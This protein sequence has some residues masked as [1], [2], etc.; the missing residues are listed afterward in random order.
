MFKRSNRGVLGVV[1]IL[2]FAGCRSADVEAPG[3]P[4]DS[5]A[6][7]SLA[8][9]RLDVARTRF[10]TTVA[11]RSE[12]RARIVRRP[13]PV[14]K[15]G[16]VSG[17]EKSGGHLRPILAERER[18]QPRAARVALPNMA[19]D[20][21]LLEDTGSDVRASVTLRGA[22][23]TPASTADGHA[24]YVGGYRG[25]DIIH[26]VTAEGTEDF[27]HF[28]TKP[29]KESLEYDLDV[30]RVAGLRLIGDGLELLD[31]SGTP[32]IHVSPPWVADANG[33]HMARLS[34]EGCAFDSNPAPPWGRA[35]TPP[36]ADHC[37]VRVSWSDVAYPAL[38]DPSWTTTATMTVYRVGTS[39]TKL[40][41]GRVLFAADGS[42]T[43]TSE[44]YDPAT[45]TFALTGNMSIP[46]LLHM[47]NLLPSGKV[48]VASGGYTANAFWYDFT[49][50]TQIFDPA[51]GTWTTGPA[52]PF[53]G[54]PTYSASLANGDVLYV[55]GGNGAGA[56]YRAATG[57]FV[58]TGS[59]AQRRTEP[60]L[61]TLA[62]GKVLVT[63]GWSNDL[64]SGPIVGAAEIFDP[65]ANGG[66]GAFSAT[67]A[68]V[69]GRASHTATLLPSGK[70][71]IAG[72]DGAYRVVEIF[73]PAAAGG[74]GA[75]SLAPSM[76]WDHSSHQA[77]LLPSGR[78][79]I[80][81]YDGFIGAFRPGHN[82]AEELDPVLGSVVQTGSQFFG[83]DWTHTAT[84]LN[85][86][87]VLVGPYDGIHMSVYDPNGTGAPPPCSTPSPVT[88]TATNVAGGIKLDWTAA[89]TPGG[90]I[91]YYWK[92]NATW[93]IRQKIYSATTTTFTDPLPAGTTRKFRIKPYND[94][95]ANAFYDPSVDPLGTHSNEVTGTAL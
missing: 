46:R 91:I 50:D 18:S 6:E 64:A 90:Y 22:S 86:G 3:Q 68:M 51:L 45:N 56:I 92:N 82:V 57:T 52:L 11:E 14:L 33:K 79:L 30:S 93:S 94:C 16:A 13:V 17:F 15:A 37:T 81:G 4:D 75:F 58:T 80:T 73:D 69:A 88:L 40:Q 71:L 10:Q 61:T 70:V 77:T 24:V 19:N 78:V 84:L 12:D 53:P 72:G 87:K 26:R 83:F 42:G 59:L 5:I 65:A 55:S 31:G 63:G 38:V 1:A 25:A 60:A 43:T 9:A 85:S 47:A 66:V 28:E 36:G 27:I 32:A 54:A 76:Q 39:A 62:S 34:V 49:N 89:P 74:V 23:P 8:L 29:A 2:S 7:S 67:G 20:A 21:V 35:V 95:D 48:I 41:S 44:I